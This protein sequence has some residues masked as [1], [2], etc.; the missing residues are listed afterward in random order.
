MIHPEADARAK[1][2]TSSLCLFLVLSVVAIVAVQ[3]AHG[4]FPGNLPV[5]R[6]GRLFLLLAGAA[7]L[8]A[9]SRWLLARDRIT[10]DRLGLAVD[11][12]HGRA[13]VFGTGLGI[14]HI[15]VLMTVF[16]VAMPFEIGDGPRTPADVALSGLDYLAGNFIEELLARGYL[17][18]VLACWLGTTRAIWL[19]AIPFGL[20]HLPGLDPVAAVKMMFTTGAMHFVYA[21]AYLATRSLWAALA[22]HAVGNTLLHSVIGVDKPGA[23]SLQFTRSLPET[24]D[25]PF[26][27]FFG[28]T[29]LFAWWMSRWSTTRHGAAWLASESGPA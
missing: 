3:S 19:M 5:A 9:G 7:V 8:I 11:A 21:Y 4:F 10:D 12:A 27:V 26:L 15:V 22:L 20:F 1:P 18:I 14:L 6:I 2:R 13:F 28:M 25:L 29:A 23:V 16:Y 24:V 17:L